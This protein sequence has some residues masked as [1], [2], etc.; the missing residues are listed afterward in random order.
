VDELTLAGRL[1]VATPA[2]LGPPFERSVVLLLEHG[3][4]GAVGVVLNRPSP[5]PVRAELPEWG[6]SP[7][8]AGPDVLFEGG[9][10]EPGSVLVV[11]LAVPDGSAPLSG[12]H[13]R[14]PRVVVVPFS[15]APAEAAEWAEGVRV[16][17]GYAGWAPGQL[18]AELAGGYWYVVESRPG[19]LV[20]SR[21]EE[22]WRGV[23][24]RQRDDVALVSTWTRDPNLN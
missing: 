12:L 1:V 14:A 13:P 5:V 21:P 16:F 18:E 4:D 3:A 23:L 22:L 11:A 10:V 20:A 7:V 19:D 2:L 24:R 6:A 9:P 15:A 17:A 8:L